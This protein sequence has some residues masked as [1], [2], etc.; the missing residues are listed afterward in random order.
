VT[1]TILQRDVEEISLAVDESRDP[2]DVDVDKMV[3]EI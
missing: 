1:P 3:E 2:E